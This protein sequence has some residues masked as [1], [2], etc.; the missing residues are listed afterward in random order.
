MQSQSTQYDERFADYVDGEL[1][2]SELSA[3]E[4]ELRRDERLREAL[5]AYRDVVERVREMPDEQAPAE[6][7]NLVQQRIRRKTRGRFYGAAAAMGFPY[8]A[9]VSVV[10]LCIMAAIYLIGN[11]A[12]G[13]LRPA[14]A[15]ASAALPAGVADVVAMEGGTVNGATERCDGQPEISLPPT[16]LAKVAGKLS[17][18]VELS[19]APGEPT[20]RGHIR[21]CAT[22]T[23]D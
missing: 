5:D 6:L 15:R 7:L 2:A 13:E 1:S 19:K 11:P 21:Y 23:G 8:Q 10:L 3:L 9:A 22:V 18:R 16:A 12:E 14:G 20:A 4:E 17:G